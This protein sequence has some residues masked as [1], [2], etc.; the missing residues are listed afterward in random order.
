LG[1][2]VALQKGRR[3]GKILLHYFGPEEL[4]RLI[5]MLLGVPKS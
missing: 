1:T 3:G 4:D 2:R 5:E